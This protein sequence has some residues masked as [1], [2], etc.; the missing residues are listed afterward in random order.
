MAVGSFLFLKEQIKDIII[1]LPACAK[2]TPTPPPMHGALPEA[3]HVAWRVLLGPTAH[4]GDNQKFLENGPK[5]QAS[6][7]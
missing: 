4:S 5:H 1:I 2:L 3:A 6:S 7:R